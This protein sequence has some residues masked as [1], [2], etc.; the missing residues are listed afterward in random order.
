MQRY[1]DLG[2]DLKVIGAQGCWTNIHGISYDMVKIMAQ[3]WQ[4]LPAKWSSEK[5]S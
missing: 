2:F 3:G 5:W 4:K 1:I